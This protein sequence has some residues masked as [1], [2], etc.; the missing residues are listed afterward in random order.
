MES[1]ASP[2]ASLPLGLLIA[3]ALVVLNGFFVGAEFALVRVR[4]SRLKALARL[5]SKPA[6][7]ADHLVHHLDETLSVCQVGIT[8]T[9]LGLG[10]IGEPVFAVLM[11][12][13]LGPADPWL[14]SFSLTVSLASAFFLITFLHVVL[15]ELV[16]KSMAIALAERLSLTLAPPLRLCQWLLFPLVALLNGAARLVLRP[17]RLPDPHENAD[18]SV[19]EMK[20]LIA[21]SVERG[22]IGPLQGRMLE[23]LF[24]F[25]KRRARDVMVPLARVATLDLREPWVRL[26]ARIRDEGYS[27]YP[28]HSGDLDRISRVLHT[29]ALLPTLITGTAPP[30]LLVLAQPCPIVPE[31]LP[32]ERLLA[33][34]Q[35]S[36]AHMT[37]VANEYGSTVGIVTLEDVIEE[38][39]GE[40][41]DE[42][43]AEEIDPIRAR[44][45]GGYLLDPALPVDRAAELIADTPEL[46]EGV[47]TVAGLLQTELGR[48]PQTGDSIAFGAT[49][50][51]VAAHVQGT[52]ILEIAL[53]PRREDRDP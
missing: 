50:R 21:R 20:Q 6:E 30:D 16:P 8:L 47:H 25:A 2:F 42:F 5:G 31:T 4:P 17:L 34:L 35:A 7:I 28:L 27:R 32:L 22:A 52:R 14:G 49:H 11:R 19:D 13:L 26:L 24:P 44:P 48:L 36:R 53:I 29:K 46:P 1:H 43:D 12:R 3:L 45:G 9:S 37:I 38:L 33:T 23:N 18:P 15:G 10:W 40:L 39:V 51:L 41:R